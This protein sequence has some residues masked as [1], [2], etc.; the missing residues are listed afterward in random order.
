MSGSTAITDVLVIGA[1]PTGL[2]AANACLLSGRSVTVL[3]RSG[4]VGGLARS[5]RIVGIEIDP[6]GH[7]LLANTPRQQ[8]GWAELASRLGALHLH[9]VGRRSGILRD[10]M[11]IGYPVDWQQFRAAL[12]W[13]TRA[14]AA[15]SM[16]YR[17]VLPVRPDDSLSAWV[18]N[19]YG[20]YL[21]GSLMDPHAR[22]VFGVEPTTIPATWAPQRI[23][24]P[25]LR[26]A[27]AA[28]LPR[29]PF[30]SEVAVRR[31]GFLYPEGGLGQL[32]SRYAE[33]LIGVDFRFHTRPI[34][35]TRTGGGRLSVTTS[36]PAGTSTIVAQRVISTALPEDLAACLGLSE[37]SLALTQH[38]T[39]RDLI[40]ALVRLASVPKGWAQYQWLYTHDRGVLAHRFQNYGA[41]TGLRCPPGLIGLEYT[42][43]AGGSP[44]YT[45]HVHRDLSIIYD[46]EF[47]VLGFDTL[48]DA[49]ANFEATRAL[50][51]ELGD[52]L[53]RFGPGLISTGRQGAGVYINLDQALRL[54]LRAAAEPDGWSGVL[55]G[56]EYSGYQERR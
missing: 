42:L 46:G 1:G 29:L 56:G 39:R 49:Y 17:R 36:A 15:A 5:A 26:A 20:D 6:G 31:D 27:L 16:V 11:V 52:E 37:L 35:V 51:D 12:P 33:S 55:G 23:A 25:P 54:G 2:A 24:V 44:D 14:L 4:A 47:E 13:P 10:G 22:K 41:W 28:A 53:A 45:E 32:W 48:P 18:T 9:S 7:R 34:Q 43:P 30:Q 3:E 50:L 21:T 8:R 38:S 19:R 40:V